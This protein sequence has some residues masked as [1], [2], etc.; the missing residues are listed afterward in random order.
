MGYLGIGMWEVRV[1]AGAKIQVS[2]FPILYGPH[3]PCQAPLSLSGKYVESWKGI[4]LCGCQSAKK[5]MKEQ[6]SAFLG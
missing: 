2:S 5:E 1:R 6:T 3:C 4:R